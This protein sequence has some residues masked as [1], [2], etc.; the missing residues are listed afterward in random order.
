MAPPAPGPASPLEPRV[1]PLSSP[2]HD[3]ESPNYLSHRHR[4]HTNLSPRGESSSFSAATPQAATPPFPSAICL[5]PS[6]EF[7]E[8]RSR[9]AGVPPFLSAPGYNRLC[10]SFYFSPRFRHIDQLPL[11]LSSCRDWVRPSLPWKRYRVAPHLPRP[12]RCCAATVSPT[13]CHHA[14]QIPYT[15]RV[16]VTPPPLHLVDRT[17]AGGRAT[18]D[19]PHVVPEVR[20]TSTRA[21][22]MGLND[23]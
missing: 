6:L 16:L 20:G 2:S 21:T 22:G 8:L 17:T 1:P 9:S 3:V 10:M 18:V 4:S 13:L 12:L 14:R 7:T 15:T 5:V 19:A 23:R 11:L